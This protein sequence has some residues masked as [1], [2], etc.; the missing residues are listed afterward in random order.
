MS[1][2]TIVRRNG[3]LLASIGAVAL[4]GGLLLSGSLRA[5]S[6]SAPLKPNLTAEPPN[7]QYFATEQFEG[8]TR[9]LVKFNGYIH[10]KGPGAIDIRGKRTTNFKTSTVEKAEFDEQHQTETMKQPELEELSQPAMEVKQ[11]EF[12]TEPGHEESNIER[13]H[14]DQPSSAELIYSASDGHDHWHLQHLARYSLWDSTKSHEVTIGQK[15]G[16]CLDDSLHTESGIGPS[17]SVYSDN[18]APFR[19]FC[20]RYRPDATSLFEGI[21]VG[22]SDLY[23]SG[24]AWQWVD[25][26]N[27]APGEY[28]LRED[29]NPEGKIDEVSEP[30]Q[31]A[32]SAQRTLLPGYDANPQ[33]ISTGYGQ[34]TTVTLGSA[35]WEAT[36]KEREQE[37]SPK[38]G[39]V[40]YSIAG[41]PSHGTLG[42]L[43]GNQITYTPETGY[44]GPDSF[45]FK[46]RDTS[47]SFPVE[48]YVATVSIQVGATVTPSVTIA[49]APSALTV[50]TAGKLTATFANDP[51]PVEWS[52]SGG[53]I[54]A[55]GAEHEGATLTAPGSAGA[56]TV[57]ARLA[58]QPSVSDSVEVG[59]LAAPPAEP[60]LTLPPA[61]GSGGVAGQTVS[62][63]APSVSL[64]RAM[65]SGRKLIMTTT[66]SVA[67]RVRLS[68]WLGLRHLG[69]C[70]VLSPAGRQFTCRVLL[71]PRVGVR[72]KIRIVAS[73][74]LGS[75]WIVR[76]L[77]PERIPQMKMT[78]AGAHAGIASAGG[79]YWC[80]PGTLVET[81]ASE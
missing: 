2:M 61:T 3:R 47:S 79:V 75:N 80:S 24:L 21:S 18:V 71:G 46:A 33:G 62:H 19:R 69:T 17:S 4:V 5:A 41:G 9:L 38:T 37:K 30:N 42:T 15:V 54:T 20:Q 63:S 81:L 60:A 56:V 28:W 65:R 78:A 39:G 34:A 43:N 8:R 10:N 32:W 73:L 52:T 22:W 14:V 72:A 40:A 45:T 53:S 57:T 64:P 68:A 11:R 66:P 13:A 12:T 7:G 16:F 26:S 35:K 1:W 49:T 29:V 55:E 77:A 51:G 44:S 23:D 48:P 67:G 27:L 25:V 31:P 59:V 76:R 74:R 50:G 58:D 6:A 70:E 36:T